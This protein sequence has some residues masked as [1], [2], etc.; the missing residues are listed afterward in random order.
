MQTVIKEPSQEN[1][2][3]CEH[4][5]LIISSYHRWT[6]KDL[7]KQERSGEGIY[8]ALYKAPYGVVSHNTEDDPIFNYGNQT[9]LR[10]FEM[11]WPEFTKLASRK[12]AEPVNRAERERL[13]NHVSK[14][15]FIDDYRGV[16]ISSS[17]KR[18]MI[19][20]ATVWNI[21]DERGVY[22]GQAAVFYRWSEV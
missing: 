12:S 5:E 6:G 16:R 8:R 20:D 9:A 13:I 21:V 4:A 22:Y 7:V 1:C 14:Q 15:G 2:Y 18:F 19:E 17:G 10:L 11:D 3:L